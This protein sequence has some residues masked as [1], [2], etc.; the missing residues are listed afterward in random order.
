MKDLL[1]RKKKL[2]ED[3]IVMLIIIQRK[4]PQKLKDLGSFHISYTI[5]SLAIGR[6]LCDPGTS[7]NLMPLSIMNKLGI[8]KVKPTMIS[9][10]LADRSIKFLYGVVEDV[11]VKINK[12]IFPVDFVVLDMEEDS[13]MPLILGRPFLVTGKALI[14]VQQG[15]LVLRVHD[16][17]VIFKVFKTM[18]HPMENEKCMRIDVIDPLIK[19]TFKQ[20]VMSCL[21]EA[22]LVNSTILEVENEEGNLPIVE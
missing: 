7:I 4:L 21:L 3:E 12:F 6:A 9:L 20:E 22:T 13:E 1:P 5:R 8:K 14:D 11:L 10:Q 19:E 17:K 16:E 2:K 18:K 15:E